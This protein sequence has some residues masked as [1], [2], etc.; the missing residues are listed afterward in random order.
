MTSCVIAEDKDANDDNADNKPE[1]AFVDAGISI[2]SDTFP[3][4]SKLCGCKTEIQSMMV[5]GLLKEVLTMPS[6][7]NCKIEYTIFVSNA[8]SCLKNI[9][10]HSTKVAFLKRSGRKGQKWV[11]AILE[12]LPGNKVDAA[13]WL[14]SYL[15]N[16]YEDTFTDAATKMGLPCCLCMDPYDA[17]RMRDEANVNL[18]QQKV[19][20]QY[21]RASLGKKICIP[22]GNVRE[23][24]PSQLVLCMPMR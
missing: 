6:V 1:L 18:S 23:I 21:L 16:H 19:I 5:N 8:H 4:L 7:S 20:K 12:H 17:I 10:S 9:P 15:G 13:R 11:E 2:D 22:D 3:I 24:R 14:M